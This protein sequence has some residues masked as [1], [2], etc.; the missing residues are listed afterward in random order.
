M[1]TSPP[2]LRDAQQAAIEDLFERFDVAQR[3]SL[4]AVLSANHRSADLGPLRIQL[5]IDDGV[6]NVSFQS[7]HP[8]TRD[9]LE[10]AM[11]RLR[12]LLAENGLSLGQADVGDDGNDRKSHEALADARSSATA[13]GDDSNVDEQAASR[14]AR[15][16]ADGLVDTFA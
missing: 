15:R 14:V 8:L 7:Q 16:V 2:E 4:G 5:E 10:Q 9:A 3:T 12:E 13:A 1:L 11:P 6:A